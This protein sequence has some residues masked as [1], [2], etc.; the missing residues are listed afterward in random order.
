MDFFHGDKIVRVGVLFAL[1][2]LIHLYIESLYY[3]FL[4][5]WKKYWG[6]FWEDMCLVIG[7]SKHIILAA[8]AYNENPMCSW[9]LWGSKFHYVIATTRLIVKYVK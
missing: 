6:S 8:E 9:N 7:H 4:T 2:A 5:T 3:G 1:R